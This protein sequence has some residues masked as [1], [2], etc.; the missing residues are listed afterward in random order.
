MT[1]PITHVLESTHESISSGTLDP[2]RRAALTIDSGD[3]VS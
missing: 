2:T 1:E 3:I